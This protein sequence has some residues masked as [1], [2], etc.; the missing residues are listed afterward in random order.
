MV[1]GPARAVYYT[2]MNRRQFSLKFLFILT[3]LV[4]VTCAVPGVAFVEFA[5]LVF[6]LT[7]LIP[8]LVVLALGFGLS[9]LGMSVVRGIDRLSPANGKQSRVDQ[10]A[11]RMES[12]GGLAD[13]RSG[14]KV[15]NS[16]NS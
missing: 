4:A 3:A 14:G 12:S 7:L 11:D 8:A 10:T 6:L 1:R 2:L 13:S 5:L 16:S 9:S 15:Q